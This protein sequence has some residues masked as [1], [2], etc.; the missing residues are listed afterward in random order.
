MESQ[1]ALMSASNLLQAGGFQVVNNNAFQVG[2]WTDLELSRGRKTA[3]RAK[4]A[5]QCP[6]QLRL[7]FDRGRVNVAASITPN[8][9]RGRSF[10]WGGVIGLLAYSL[11]NVSKNEQVHAGLMVVITQSI[12]RLLAFRQPPEEAR[13]EWAE[14]ETQIVAAARKARRRSLIVAL[15][16]IFLFVALITTVIIVASKN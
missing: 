7:E 3:A 14:V 6:Q 1:E 8:T 13:R 16:I 2:G 5:T 11:S 12:E 10:M 15:V 9:R 4:D